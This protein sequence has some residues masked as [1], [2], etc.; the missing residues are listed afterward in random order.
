MTTS[1]EVF[2]DD[3]VS[4]HSFETILPSYAEATLPSYTP[5]AAANRPSQYSGNVAS[6]TPSRTRVIRP[7]PVPQPQ[8]LSISQSNLPSRFTGPQSPSFPWAPKIVYS[9]STK[10]TKRPEAEINISF[11][12]TRP[13]T[14]AM[15]HGD[16]S[17]LPLIA[18]R[19]SS[20]R[21]TPGRSFEEETRIRELDELT[22]AISRQNQQNRGQRNYPRP[23]A[24]VTSSLRRG[25]RLLG[26]EWDNLAAET[27]MEEI[28]IRISELEGQIAERHLLPPSARGLLHEEI[29][30]LKTMLSSRRDDV[31]EILA[32]NIAR[33]RELKQTGT[34]VSHVEKDQIKN[35]MLS[36]K[37]EIQ[38]LDERAGDLDKLGRLAELDGGNQ[39]RALEDDNKN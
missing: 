11:R 20:A 35:D 8:I 3:A 26:K 28:V 33:L 21:V 38:F 19:A 39:N 12:N 9:A 15:A 23:V 5:P 22:R 32:S 7:P 14:Q 25:S 6:R 24:Q 18:R 13:P 29:A 30:S 36:M 34:R 1:R 17:D 16:T 2:A 31:S 27:E 37:A 10:R 4:I